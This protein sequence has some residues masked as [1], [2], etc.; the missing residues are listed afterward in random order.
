MKLTAH[1]AVDDRI[2]QEVA[3]AVRHHIVLDVG[4]AGDSIAWAHN[5][6]DVVDDIADRLTRAAVD[7]GVPMKLS[8][9]TVGQSLSAVAR[10]LHRSSDRG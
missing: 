3:Y 7:A 8:R 6:Q 10:P 1:N 9:P 5:A 4:T 2:K